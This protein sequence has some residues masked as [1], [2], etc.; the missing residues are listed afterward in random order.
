M[1]I[2]AGSPPLLR[3][4]ALIT[5]TPAPTHRFKSKIDW[6]LAILL[7]IPPIAAVTTPLTL[8]MSGEPG[9]AFSLMTLFFVVAIYGGLVFPMYYEIGQEHLIIRFGLVR[10]RVPFELIQAVTPT[11]NPLSSPALSLDRL[12]VNAGN[13]LGPNISPADKTGFLRALSIKT[14]QL[15]L[16]GDRLVP[17]GSPDTP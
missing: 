1:S 4:R 7:L 13:A 8:F 5:Q 11:R 3:R 12:H 2:C 15:E 17:R 9:A 6:W 14:P 10:S 16:R